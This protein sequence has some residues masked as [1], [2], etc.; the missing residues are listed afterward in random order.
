MRWQGHGKVGSDLMSHPLSV[1]W[2]YDVIQLAG[3]Y[4]II[5][6]LHDH[7]QWFKH[8]SIPT[9]GHRYWHCDELM[10]LL[11]RLDRA[12]RRIQDFGPVFT[13]HDQQKLDHLR[14]R[15]MALVEQASETATRCQQRL[16]LGDQGS[17]RPLDEQER[18]LLLSFYTLHVIEP[19][20]DAR[21]HLLEELG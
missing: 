11:R 13:D 9:L 7:W 18:A 19:L 6:E 8:H 1:Q 14:N 17:S 2:P 3:G 21:A 5:A 12:N 16:A 20:E 10:P 15:A 4:M